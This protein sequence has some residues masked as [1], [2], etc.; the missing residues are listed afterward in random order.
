MG[1]AHR[2]ATTIQRPVWRLHLPG[3][4]RPSISYAIVSSKDFPTT[5]NDLQVVS[6]FFHKL[7][8]PLLAIFDWE[9]AYSQILKAVHQWPFL[10][11]RNFDDK[12]ILDTSITFGGVAGCGAFGRPADTWKM[13]IKAEF[14]VLEIFRWEDDNMLVKA[15]P[16]AT[17]ME[18]VVQRSNELGVRTNES[19]YSPFPAE[20]KFNSFVWNGLDKTVRLPDEKAEARIQQIHSFLVQGRQ[21]TR[22]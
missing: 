4:P 9:K 16:S 10:M 14:D 1:P 22:R 2:G 13:I 7:T 15:L 12:M 18:D 17:S 5:W 20:Q 6:S 8:R 19:K 3:G 11:I 21:D